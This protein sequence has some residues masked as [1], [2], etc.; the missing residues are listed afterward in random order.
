MGLLRSEEKMDISDAT[1][2]GYA[3]ALRRTL[4]VGKT[5]SGNEVDLPSN[6]S[7]DLVRASLQ[8]FVLEL[9]NTK[10]ARDDAKLQV[11][12]LEKKDEDLTHQKE[13]TQ[14]RLEQIQKALG[15]TEQGKRGSEAK[16]ANAQTALLLQEETI[17]R[18]ERERKD[19]VDRLGEAQRNIKG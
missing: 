10:S 7:V 18:T 2:N 12:Q 13:H 19:L 11:N 14:S 9:Q 4:G 3:S 8:Q 6:P 15:E 16:L 5:E 17:R 1:L